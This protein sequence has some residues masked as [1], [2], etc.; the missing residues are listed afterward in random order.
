VRDGLGADR[1]A[2]AGRPGEVERQRE[3]G[4]MPFAEPPAAEDEVV[5]RHLDER[6]I[7]RAARRRR[8]DD[9]VEGAPRHD[10]VHTTR[11]LSHA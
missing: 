3:P 4:G 10:A 1:L 6:L 11:R 2:G 5:A 7:E 9:V 8:Q